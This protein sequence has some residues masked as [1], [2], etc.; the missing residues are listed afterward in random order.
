MVGEPRDL[1]CRGL[2]VE[3]APGE[4]APH[5][6]GKVYVL[7]G[8]DGVLLR[9]VTPGVCGGH[10]GLRIFGRLD[11]PSALRYLRL[12]YYRKHRVFFAG[13]DVALTAGYR[14][15]ARCLPDAYAAWKAGEGKPGL[16][17]L[18]N[19]AIKLN[20]PAAERQPISATT[21]AHPLTAANCALPLHQV[22]T[23][24]DTW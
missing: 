21:G 5:V 3:S 24:I 10:S 12:G 7:L 15:C 22:H 4:S 23:P 19:A 9:S 11:C 18:A 13:A 20:E 1:N 16:L 14:P 2:L 8:S 6:R 17:G